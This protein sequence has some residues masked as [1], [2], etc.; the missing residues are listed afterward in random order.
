MRYRIFTEDKGNKDYLALLVLEKFEGFTV[1]E[2][3][4][5]Y[6]GTKEKSLCF[7]IDTLAEDNR[8]AV[9]KLAETIKIYNK[10]EC[11]LLQT[12]NKSYLI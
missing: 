8:I 6:K 2:C 12:E 1:F 7:E 4:G 10:Q 11:V 5:Y 9:F 3:T